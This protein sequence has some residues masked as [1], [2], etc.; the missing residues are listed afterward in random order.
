MY[1]IHIKWEGGKEGREGVRQDRGK[2]RGRQ[3]RGENRG[4]QCRRENRGRQRR[5][6]NRGRK[7]SS[8]KL[9]TIRI[10]DRE[11]ENSK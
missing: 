9:V 8:G 3:R 6:E 4:R 5:R 1:D 11:N 7:S 2:N 10:D